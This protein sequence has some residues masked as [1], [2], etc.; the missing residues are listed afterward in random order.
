MAQSWKMDVGI[1]HVGAYQVS[2]KPYAQADVDASSAVTVSFP[3]VTK[4]VQVTNKTVTP[5]KVGFSA[6][7]IAG[8][9][10]VGPAKSYFTVDASSSAGGYGV[11]EIFEM[12]VSQ[13]FL[14]GGD[15]VDVVAGLT[16][17]LPERT[18]MGAGLLSWSGSV[19][20]G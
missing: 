13:L 7:G 6:L 1:N 16:N 3:Y 2:G 17:I 9:A 11:S 20:V 12:K 15:G 10:Q 8:T 4:W 18:L 5:L 19:G 14:L